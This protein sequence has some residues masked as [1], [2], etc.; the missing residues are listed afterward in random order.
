MVDVVELLLVVV[1][2]CVVDVM[3]VVEGCVDDDM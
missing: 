1:G 3:L 2:G